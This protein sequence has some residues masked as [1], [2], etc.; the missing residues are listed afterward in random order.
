M[1]TAGS[2]ERVTTPI[3]LVLDQ[4]SFQTEA[5][6]PD[7]YFLLIFELLKEFS[8]GISNILQKCNFLYVSFSTTFENHRLSLHS[9]LNLLLT[10][11]RCDSGT[12]TIKNNV[13]KGHIFIDLNRPDASQEIREIIDGKDFN[14]LQL[15]FR[16]MADFIDRA[17]GGKAF[18][19]I[20]HICK[21]HS[22]LGHLQT[23]KL[24]NMCQHPQSLNKILP[25]NQNFTAFFHKRIRPL[26]WNGLVDSEAHLL[27]D[28]I[29]DLDHLGCLKL[30]SSTVCERFSNRMT[31]SF[32][33]LRNI[34]IS[35]VRHLAEPT[36]IANM[37]EWS[38]LQTCYVYTKVACKSLKLLDVWFS[39]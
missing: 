13:W 26:L 5:S 34:M 22:E 17:L 37:P 28:V 23:V 18:Q 35:K 33:W 36:N 7:M 19:P 8:L 4:Y 1:F 27:D 30:Q 12:K 6:V 9:V 14:Q 20:T 31:L 21:N 39:Q 15:V 10:T 24:W 2:G 25:I 16:F 29:G 3:V 11:F 32:Q 38:M